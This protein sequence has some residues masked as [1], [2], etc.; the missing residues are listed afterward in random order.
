VQKEERDSQFGS[1]GNNYKQRVL[2]S[3]SDFSRL[4]N[5]GKRHSPH[6]WLILNYKPNNF[7]YLR[8]GMT[9]SKKIG[10]AVIRNRLKRWCREFFREAIKKG[11]D[12]EVDINVVF[13]PVNIEFYKTLKHD[14]VVTAL[15]AGLKHVR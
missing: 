13:K 7:G 5:G 11:I 10:S 15:E 9:I 8:F 14:E 3:P 1:V 12:L 2:R 6:H 4:K